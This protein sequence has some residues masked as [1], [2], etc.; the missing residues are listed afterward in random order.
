MKTLLEPKTDI[1]HRPL[2]DGWRMTLLLAFLLGAGPAS[3]QGA[4]PRLLTTFTNPTPAFFELFGGSV[5]AMGTDRVLISAGAAAGGG[6]V[7]LFNLNGTLLTTFTNPGTAGNGF[8]G[9]GGERGL[10]AMGTDRVLI[11]AFDSYRGEPLEQIG[12]A[13]LFSTNG[14]LLTTFTNPNPAKVQAFGWSLAAVGNDRVIISGLANINKPP[15][16]PGGVYLFTTNGTLLTTFTNPTPAIHGE[17]GVSLAVIE[18][19]RVLIGASSVGPVGAGVAYLFSTNGALLTTITNPVP[20]E[21][22][23]FGTAVAVVGSD[24]LLISAT[25]AAATKGNGGSAYLFTTNGTLLATFPNPTPAA[26]DLFG[27]SVAAVGSSRVI[28]GASQDGAGALRSGA[29]Y[30]FSTNGTLLATITN[31]T[32]AVNDYFGWAVAAVGSDEVIIGSVWKDLG[33]TDAG[34]AYLFALSNPSLSIA[35]NATMISLSWVTPESSWVLQQ[36]DLPGPTTLW[37]DNTNAVIVSGP[38]NIVQQE[39]DT[40]NRIFRL[41]LP[42]SGF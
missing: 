40:S 32:P 23:N 34:A 11:G 10:A 12:A 25:D 2:S 29:A 24:R 30:V 16:Y 39:L 35:R 41:H 38:T 15:P 21:G 17:F 4:N 31:P 33:A 6:K 22:I 37:S 8:G 28:I 19:N 7:F 27:W 1:H 9:L 42:R 5:A 18:G 26:N 36:L 3:A 13:F 14:T 20:A